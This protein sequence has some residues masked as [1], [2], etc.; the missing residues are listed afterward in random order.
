[1]TKFRPVAAGIIID[2]SLKNVEE[3]KEA[4]INTIHK[5]GNQSFTEDRIYVYHPEFTYI[6]TTRGSQIASAFYFSRIENLDVESSLK[7][8]TYIVGY[9]EADMRK[10]VVLITDKYKT[11]QENKYKKPLY[12][13]RKERFGCNFQFIGLGE[14]PF[15]TFEEF[16]EAE[17]ICLEASDLETLLLEKFKHETIDESTE[18]NSIGNYVETICEGENCSTGYD[19]H[20]DHPRQ[21]TS[22]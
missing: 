22:H 1:M 5:L 13:N 4:I 16:P 8:T 15:P 20:G 10:H 7:Q 6:P 12:I 3:T 18:D 19:G 9:E 21:E 17:F 2:V 14:Q 11:V